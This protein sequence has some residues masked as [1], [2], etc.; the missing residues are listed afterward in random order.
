MLFRG[1]EFEEKNVQGVLLGFINLLVLKHLTRFIACVLA[2]PR[3]MRRYQ[4]DWLFVH[5]THTPFLLFGLLA[6]FCGKKLVIVLTDG[7]V[8]QITV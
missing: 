5:G 4:V 8:A 7:F 1:G 6:K 3:L 2:L